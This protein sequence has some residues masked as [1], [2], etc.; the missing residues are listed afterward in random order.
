MLYAKALRSTT[1]SALNAY[2]SHHIYFCPKIQSHASFCMPSDKSWMRDQSTML[3]KKGRQHERK[4]KIKRIIYFA[5]RAYTIYLS[6]CRLLTV[7][8]CMICDESFIKLY[9]T[10]NWWVNVWVK[11]MTPAKRMAVELDHF[12]YSVYGACRN[13]CKRK[14]NESN[15][16]CHHRHME[17][18]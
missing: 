15:R 10:H 12:T 18:A 6:I 13:A 17:N 7:C 9:F 8:R 2:N 16:K 14:M 4:H 1:L 3:K 5:T 11:G